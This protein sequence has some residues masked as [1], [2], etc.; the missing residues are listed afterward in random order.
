MEAEEDVGRHGLISLA[1]LS[2]RQGDLHHG[3][4]NESLQ[5]PSQLWGAIWCR[6]LLS[7]SS[8]ET[9]SVHLVFC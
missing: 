3:F 1:G 9:L 6:I 8:W 5:P 7:Y 4:S 2:L